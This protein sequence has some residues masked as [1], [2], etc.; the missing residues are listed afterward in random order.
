LDQCGLVEQLQLLGKT[1]YN[2]NVRHT[3]TLLSFSD[4]SMRFEPH[5]PHVLLTWWPTDLFP[6]KLIAG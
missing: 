6:A 5:L 3:K 2:F 4:G 1:Q